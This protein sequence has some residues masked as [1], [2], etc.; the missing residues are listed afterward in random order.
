MTYAELAAK[1]GLSQATIKSLGSRADYN[2]TL[3]TIERLCVALGTD[4]ADLLE[5]E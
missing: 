5:W 4:P 1:T 3:R 2:A